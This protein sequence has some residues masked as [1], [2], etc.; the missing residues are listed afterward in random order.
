MRCATVSTG[1]LSR[2]YCKGD[3]K[4]LVVSAIRCGE[5]F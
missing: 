5:P 4:S 2:F 3:D 1:E